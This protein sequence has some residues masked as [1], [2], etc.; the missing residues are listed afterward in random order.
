MDSLVI[1]QTQ[2]QRTCS[3]LCRGGINRCFLVHGEKIGRDGTGVGRVKSFLFNRRKAQRGVE[4]RGAALQGE[5]AQESPINLQGIGQGKHE[6]EL[7][8]AAPAFELTDGFGGNGA[9]LGDLGLSFSR[10]FPADGQESAKSDGWVH[11]T[12]SS[13]NRCD[14]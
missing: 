5:A 13:R 6:F 14:Y 12:S 9:G 3:R 4:L 11:R 8:L 1:G 7:G 10:H 2:R